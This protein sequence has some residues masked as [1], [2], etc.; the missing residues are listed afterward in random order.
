LANENLANEG[1]TIVRTT[2]LPFNTKAKT[3]NQGE[4]SGGILNIP[5]IVKQANAAEMDSTFWIQELKDEKGNI[6]FRLQY[7]QTVMLDFFPRPDGQPGAIRW[8]H[9]SIN[10]LE[11]DVQASKE[12]YSKK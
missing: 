8:P 3:F 6:K 10:T 11:K 1:L 9:I 7:L 2:V 4:L 5:F 12:I